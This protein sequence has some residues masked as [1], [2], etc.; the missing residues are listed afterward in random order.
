MNL[1]L[2]ALPVAAPTLG[3]AAHALYLVR[4]LRTARTDRLTGLM[5][6]EEFSARAVR[7]VRHP[8][9]AVL[10]LD[11]N[12]FK[13]INDT[14][15]H[16]AGDRVIAAVGRRLAAWARERGG[17]A[18]RLG[19]D[20]FTALVR[21]APDADPDAEMTYLSARLSVPL[22]AGGVTLRPR[23]SIGLCRT[24]SMPGAGLSDLLRAADEAMYAAKRSGDAWRPAGRTTTEAEVRAGVRADVRGDVRAEVRTDVRSDVPAGVRRD[25]AVR[26]AGRPTRRPTRRAGLAAQSA[27]HLTLLQPARRR[28]S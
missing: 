27:A 10:L 11:L 26:R 15:G 9:A 6:R 22:D 12:G 21:L 4:R 14:H 8:H 17:F 3:W 5:R 2:Q 24:S 16:E 23:A 18:A 13:Q 25:A 19:G 20:E 28:A 1:I 7:A